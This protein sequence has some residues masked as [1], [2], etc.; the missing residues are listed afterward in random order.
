MGRSEFM[1]YKII[2]DSCCDLNE[3]LKK[4]LNIGLVPLNI[5]IGSKSYKDDEKLD[6][7]ML[8]HHMGNSTESPKTASPSPNNFM[9]AYK[10]SDNIFVVTL[11]SKLSGTYNSAMMAKEMLKEEIGNKFIHVF[12][13][14]SASIGET[15]VG[16]KISELINKGCDNL[17]IIDKT[18]A[19]IKEMKTL[20][21]LDSLDNLVKAGRL[22]ALKGKIASMFS[23]KPIM[24]DNGEGEI[25]VLEKVRGSKKALR[26][27]VDLIGEHGERF[28]EKI[29]G[30]A[31][32]NCLEK[33]L[34]F[35]EEVRKKYKF[36]DIIIVETAGISTV[37]ANDG[38]LIIAF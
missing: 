12:D 28:E 2:A 19:Y 29:L 32:C 10:N 33:A 30:I 6:T 24:S 9:E 22:N 35:R 23:I 3:K 26:R 8:L 15:L 27:L 20:F 31:H 5:H 16:M 17:S 13:S 11:S 34:Q 25:S 18:N 37:Y 38:G 1:K 14:L 7:K 4:R 36:K 21:V